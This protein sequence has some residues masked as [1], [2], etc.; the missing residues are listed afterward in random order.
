M[1]WSS[2]AGALAAQGQDPGLKQEEMR[3]IN[4][5]DE[6]VA[7]TDL[8]VKEHL[9]CCGSLD[10]CLAE[11]PRNVEDILQRGS[12][13]VRKVPASNEQQAPHPRSG[14]HSAEGSAPCPRSVADTQD[15]HWPFVYH[16]CQAGFFQIAEQHLTKM[17]TA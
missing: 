3:H 11:M 7:C 16:V 17:Q 15:I 1:P 2:R 10:I 13:T 5:P 9:H 6:Q 4:R 12:A 14:Q 8:V